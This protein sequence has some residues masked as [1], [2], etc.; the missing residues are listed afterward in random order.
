MK[1]SYKKLRA[2][3][4]VPKHALAGDAGVDLYTPDA[5]AIETGE[6]KSIPLGF[7][8]EIPRGYVGLIWDK[9]GLSHKHGLKTFG[10]V[11][12]SNFRGEMQVSLMNF[13]E[14]VFNF[15]KGHKVAQLLIQKVEE[16]EFEEV[17]DLSDSVRGERAFGSTGK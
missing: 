3:A 14:K 17:K 1:I 8:I 4:I 16:V 11:V 13:S 6:Q 15:E 2:D 5:C 12:D 10:G 9:G 7:A